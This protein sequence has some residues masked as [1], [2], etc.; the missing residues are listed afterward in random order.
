MGTRALR[1]EPL[2]IEDDLH[3]RDL[4]EK[5]WLFANAREVVSVGLPEAAEAAAEAAELVL[6]GRSGLNSIG[7]F[8]PLEVVKRMARQ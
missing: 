5:E 1:H 7:N 3:S 2:L 4:A 8:H 6:S